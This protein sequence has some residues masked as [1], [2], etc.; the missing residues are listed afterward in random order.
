MPLYATYDLTTA[1]RV[2]RWRSRGRYH[3]A[4]VWDPPVA[5][6]GARGVALRKHGGKRHNP[7]DLT[8]GGN[9]TA[10]MFTD[11]LGAYVVTYDC[12]PG[13]LW[14]GDA[15]EIDLEFADE[16]PASDALFAMLVR[17]HCT[18][19]WL[20]GTTRTIDPSPARWAAFGES[21]GAYDVIRSQLI[22]LGGFGDLA[23]RESLRGGRKYRFD[24]DHRCGHLFLFIGQNRL[25]SFNEYVTND[26]G[27]TD[28]VAENS[29]GSNLAGASVLRVVGDVVALRRANR[30]RVLTTTAA[31]TVGANLAGATTVTVSAAFPVLRTG[32]WVVINGGTFNVVA[33]YAGGA[34]S[35][36]IF[37]ALA[38]DVANGSPI[39]VR[40][41]VAVTADVAAPGSIA[42]V[43][44]VP[45]WPTLPVAITAGSTVELQ[46]FT[47]EDYGEPGWA[48]GYLFSGNSGYTWRTFPFDVKREADADFL[49]TG[50]NPRAKELNVLIAGPPGDS[51]WRIDSLTDPISFR[52]RHAL[53]PAILAERMG[54]HDT[55]D[56]A[57][58][59]F[60]LDA[61]G[62]RVA[63]YLGD[64]QNNP[65]GTNV[66]IP[67]L[68]GRNAAFS[69]AVLQSFLTSPSALGGA[70]S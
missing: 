17:A 32:T 36:S 41:D 8:L 9:T 48:S 67:W 22:P 40:F 15:E 49:L 69:P 52:V 14:R 7:R 61:A 38:S 10:Q 44:D 16:S 26:A 21:S 45:I 28:Y 11:D 60:Q 12:D 3:Y 31:T 6:T 64:R 50:N 65:G 25:S 58:L 23:A 4:A 18:D 34:G 29:G 19:P 56:M 27:A 66:A 51:L 37:P 53:T 59:A 5:F 68:L 63:A 24:P 42:T 57:E 62:A 47:M 46:H 55:G 2:I 39:D 20:V 13:G 1:S 35:L 70:F 33:D 30:L 54:L 43:L